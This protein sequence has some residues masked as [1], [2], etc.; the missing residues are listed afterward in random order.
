M[1][2]VATVA[3]VRWRK[4]RRVVLGERDFGWLGFDFMV[5]FR[6]RLAEFVWQIKRHPVENT[7]QIVTES[8]SDLFHPPSVTVPMLIV[9]AEQ[10][11][12]GTT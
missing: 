10:N 9:L 4:L 1:E 12:V 6:Y 3:D 11:L 5:G 7:T 2:K 8:F